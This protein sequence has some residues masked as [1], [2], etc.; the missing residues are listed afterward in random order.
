[1]ADTLPEMLGLL[2]QV[3]PK[4][5][6]WPFRTASARS[7]WDESEALFDKN[8]NWPLYMVV[9]EAMY[10]A[11]IPSSEFTPED[12]AVLSMALRW[13]ARQLQVA[14]KRKHSALSDIGQPA[15]PPPP[16]TRR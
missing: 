12:Y 16:E 7:V 15:L 9:K 11:D 8:P 6:S 2:A 10:R 13:K 5:P 4:G 1:M 14:G 3:F